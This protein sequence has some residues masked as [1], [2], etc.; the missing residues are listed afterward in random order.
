MSRLTVG[1]NSSPFFISLQNP[2][3]NS[4]VASMESQI[5]VKF[6]Q[7]ISLWK[8]LPSGKGVWRTLVGGEVAQE[9][10]NRYQK[11]LQ[12]L[13]IGAYLEAKASHITRARLVQAARDTW[14][15]TR[16]HIPTVAATID[17]DDEGTPKL[18]YKPTNES[19]AAE[20]A[21]RTFIVSYEPGLDIENLRL[22]LGTEKIPSEGGTQTW[23]HLVLD[24]DEGDD[25]VTTFG[26][27]IRTH[28][29]PF[30]GLG[31]KILLNRYLN[32]VAQVLGSAGATNGSLSWGS[33]AANLPADVFHILHPSVP[34]PISPN[35]AEE[36]SFTHP[37]YAS[38]R[39]V[40]QGIM[41]VMN[42][43]YGFKPRPSDPGWPVPARA[44]L[45]L[46][47][48]ESTRLL[49]AIKPPVGS[50]NG[51]KYTLTHLAHAALAMTA[52][53]DNPPS[54]ASA[55]LWLGN[56]HLRNCRELLVE[57][58][59]SRGGYTGYALGISQSRLPVSLFLTDGNT[60]PLDKHTLVKVMRAVRDDYANLKALPD[61]IS[62]MGP[63]SQLYTRNI[64][65]DRLP[66][67]NC[68]TFSSDGIAE[69]QL[70]SVFHDSFGNPIFE[71]SE[72]FLS[73]NNVHPAPFFRITS[74]KG[75]IE[76][77]ADFN[78]NLV[79]STEVQIYMETWKQFMFLALE[80]EG[81]DY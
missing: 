42:A 5:L 14:L 73:L 78:S 50:L 74:W 52:V 18:I 49:A 43:P 4:S 58:Y 46:S 30:D 39:S 1:L 28:H 75:A 13:F 33:E 6:D 38:S 48:A 25:S 59:S 67:N 60:I 63:L 68:Y 27:L 23:C 34:R 70:D 3:L 15:W 41:E 24:R 17:P 80:L 35:S 19:G 22:Q 47:N 7:N 79:S 21:D 37:C 57:P 81:D 8:E 66:P 77:S 10:M 26:L 65:T 56:L 2:P 20:W 16:F 51:K 40:L 54:V 76:L 44:K 53:A 62:Y 64:V 9:A 32:Q 11:G 29:S 45:Q 69:R 71:L 55:S 12:S 61:P 36:P 31:L 72:A